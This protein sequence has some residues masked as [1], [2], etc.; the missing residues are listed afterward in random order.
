MTKKLKTDEICHVKYLT[1][2]TFV[3]TYKHGCDAHSDMLSFI[4]GDKV[5]FKII[6]S[7]EDKF[8]TILHNEDG[9]TLVGEDGAKYWFSNNTMLLRKD[10]KKQYFVSDICVQYSPIYTKLIFKFL[11]L[12]NKSNK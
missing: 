10:C 3:R 5:Y 2:D 7:E 4:K 12:E 6:E 9:P 1:K 11:Y 8:R